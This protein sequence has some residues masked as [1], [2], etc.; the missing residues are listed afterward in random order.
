MIGNFA[1]R[2]ALRSLL[3][4]GKQDKIDEL[5]KRFNWFKQRFDRGISVQSAG[6]LEMLL[7]E[8]GTGFTSPF[9]GELLTRVF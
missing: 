7:N 9:Q 5:T 6:T 3:S 1:I 8:M 4:H 2:I